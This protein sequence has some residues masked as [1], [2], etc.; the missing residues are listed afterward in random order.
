M[1]LLC[2][3]RAVAGTGARWLAWRILLVVAV[4]LLFEAG[5]EA[6]DFGLGFNEAFS[7][8]FTNDR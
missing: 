1:L 6:V 3:T 5:D 2:G 7:D 4:N 8:V